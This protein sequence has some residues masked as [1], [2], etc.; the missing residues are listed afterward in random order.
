[1]VRQYIG[2]QQETSITC[3]VCPSRIPKIE[4]S[5]GQYALATI[6]VESLRVRNKQQMGL[7]FPM[8][9]HVSTHATHAS[10]TLQWKWVK[11]VFRLYVLTV[12]VFI[13][14]CWYVEVCGHVDD[15]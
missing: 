1:M 12:F 3:R 8:Y 4:T 9:N 11:Y 10:L 6:P 5:V 14:L 2:Y 15:V 7:K 13:E